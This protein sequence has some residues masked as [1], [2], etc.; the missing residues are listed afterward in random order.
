MKRSEAKRLREFRAAGINR[1]E[2]FGCNYAPDECDSYRA[3]KGQV[4]AIDEVPAI[5]LPG[6]D[7]RACKCI[8]LARS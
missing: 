2:V 1:V 3:I 8:Y 4:F 6:C 7:K 5:P